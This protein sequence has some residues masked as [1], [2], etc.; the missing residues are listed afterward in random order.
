MDDVDRKYQ[1]TFCRYISLNVHFY[2]IMQQFEHGV[3]FDAI[4]T[5]F[6]RGIS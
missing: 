1:G 5:I 6:M 4:F 2:E 3:E